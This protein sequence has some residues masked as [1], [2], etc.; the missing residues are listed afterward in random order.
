MKAWE[1]TLGTIT[2]LVVALYALPLVLLL[3][4]FLGIVDLT[5]GTRAPNEL[6]FWALIVVAVVDF[7]LGFVIGGRLLTVERLH[8]NGDATNRETFVDAAARQVRSSALATAGIGALIA[9]YGVLY[10]S[11][12]GS[13]DRLIY[14]LALTVAHAVF[15]AKLFSKA[16]RA[17]AELGDRT[18]A[19]ARQ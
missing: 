4:A 18:E 8:A 2:P 13:R 17:V 14:F 16:R 12:G 7:P 11:L 9:I 15:T 3:S 5:Y 1:K 10:S 19:T 6:I